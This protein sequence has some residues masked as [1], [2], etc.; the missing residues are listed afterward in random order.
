M[1]LAGCGQVT[2]ILDAAPVAAGLVARTMCTAVF[3]QGRP[4]SDVRPY[5]LG[6]VLDERLGYVDTHIDR[7]SGEVSGGLWRLP[8]M[9][10]GHAPGLGCAVGR[11]GEGAGAPVKIAPDRR[12]WP[13]GDA[14]AADAAIPDPHP[15]FAG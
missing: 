6:P 3:V 8:F 1:A 9:T 12:P 10:A 15:P 5:E 14:L 4:E 2:E 13:V 7:R 11:P